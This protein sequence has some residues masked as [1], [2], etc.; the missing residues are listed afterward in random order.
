MTDKQLVEFARAFREG[1]LDGKRS[2]Y[3]CFA[4]CAPLAALFPVHGQ[5][6]ELQEGDLG[7]INHVWLRLPD[8]RVLD[9]TADQ[10][11]ADYPPVYLGEPRDIHP[12]GGAKEAR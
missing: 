6:V 2:N 11:G 8:G 7:D 10:F 4:I 1:M 5:P 3:M 9:P 12:V